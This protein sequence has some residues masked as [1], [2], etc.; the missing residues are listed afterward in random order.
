MNVKTC[1]G[2]RMRGYV[3][4]GAWLDSARNGSCQRETGMGEMSDA[5]I[6]LY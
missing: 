3:S 4:R 5:V 1:F 2:F 6:Q